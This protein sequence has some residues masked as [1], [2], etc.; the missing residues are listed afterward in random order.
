[1][2]Y[3]ETTY[4]HSGIKER[5]RASKSRISTSCSSCILAFTY[6]VLGLRQTTYSFLSQPP[7]FSEVVCAWLI[8]SAV[9]R[10]VT[11]IGPSFL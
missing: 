7:A 5:K 8:S 2:S 3:R 1:M 9:L 10:P 11:E 6:I 4:G